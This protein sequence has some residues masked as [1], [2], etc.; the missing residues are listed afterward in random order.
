MPVYEY[1]CSECDTKF[2]KLIRTFGKTKV[3]CPS[4]G[5]AK[6]KKVMSQIAMTCWTDHDG[7][8]Q[9][10]PSLQPVATGPA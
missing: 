10:A 8:R 4:C 3:A 1:K 5:S 6:T 2:E 7:G 9:Q